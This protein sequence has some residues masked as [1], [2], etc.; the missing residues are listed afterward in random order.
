M[1]NLF[2]FPGTSVGGEYTKD[3]RWIYFE[4]RSAQHA[5]FCTKVS[6]ITSSTGGTETLSHLTEGAFT[7]ICSSNCYQT[8]FIPSIDQA[9]QES[10]WTIIRIS[11][12]F[13]L[14]FLSS[15]WYSHQP[16][17]GL[18]R[19]PSFSPSCFVII[20]RSRDWIC[21]DLCYLFR[22]IALS[23]QIFSIFS[24]IYRH[25]KWNL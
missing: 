22:T 17:C 15:V 10:V 19:F 4:E 5:S 13:I 24:I 20:G 18:P 1:S 6:S 7:A 11:Q 8:I 3:R 25:P 23:T 9:I 16:G 2:F 14:L 21:N 12:F